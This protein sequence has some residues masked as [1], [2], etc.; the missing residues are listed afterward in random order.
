MAAFVLTHADTVKEFP[1]CTGQAW[2]DLLTRE[3]VAP[4][5]KAPPIFPVVGEVVVDMLTKEPL[6]PCPELSVTTPVSQLTLLPSRLQYPTKPLVNVEALLDE[7]SVPPA[8][9][10]SPAGNKQ[11]TTNNRYKKVLQKVPLYKGTFCICRARFALL[12]ALW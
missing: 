6:L 7:P 4:N 2:V 9:P 10:A 12:K 3:V 5:F 1:V 11:L 8:A